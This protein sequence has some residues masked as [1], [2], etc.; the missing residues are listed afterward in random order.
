MDDCYTCLRGKFLALRDRILTNGRFGLLGLS[1]LNWNSMLGLLPVGQGLL[2]LSPLSRCWN[3]SRMR[4]YF[5]FSRRSLA[6]WKLMAICWYLYQRSI[7]RSTGSIIATMIFRSW[8]SNYLPCLPFKKPGSFHNKAGC[9]G[10]LN[11]LCKTFL[12]LCYR[13]DGA[14]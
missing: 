6:K 9:F 1:T 5:R 8:K 7:H 10:S 11:D 14:E 2:M 4:R 3:T 12:A 13:E